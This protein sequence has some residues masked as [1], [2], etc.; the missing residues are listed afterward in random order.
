[1]TFDRMVP[2]VVGQSRVIVQTASNA[3]EHGEAVMLWSQ[4]ARRTIEYDH[5]AADCVR[6]SERNQ[7]IVQIAE[8]TKDRIVPGVAQ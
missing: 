2:R 7:H 5:R 1:M 3:A 6:V 8:V 4:Q